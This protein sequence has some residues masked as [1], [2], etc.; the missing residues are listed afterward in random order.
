MFN[1]RYPLAVV[2]SVV[3]FTF[4]DFLS[5]VL[6]PVYNRCMLWSSDLS[7]WGSV[8]LWT[9]KPNE[10]SSSSLPPEAWFV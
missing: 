2:P 3:L 5:G 9:K 7:E 8:G 4:G 1:W 6:Y 10:D